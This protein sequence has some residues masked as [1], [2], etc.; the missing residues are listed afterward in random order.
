MIISNNT[1]VI[2][3]IGDP[4]HHSLSPFFQNAALRYLGLDY[5][6][7]SFRVKQKDLGNAV[8]GLRSI[9][10]H[11]FNVTMPHKVG[12]TSYIDSLDK[13]SM[14]AGSVN[15]VLNRNNRLI[16]FTTDGQ[17]AINALEEKGYNPNGNKIVLLGAGGASRSI[18]F[19]LIDK[20]RELVIINRTLDRAD[21][22]VNDLSYKLKNGAKVRSST[23]T[24]SNLERELVD[25]DIL[26][27]ATSIGMK[28]DNNF[29]PVKLDFIHSRLL[30]F[31]L[32]YYPL[33]TKLLREA[34]SQGA[35]TIDGLTMLVYQGAASLKIW[36][37]R[38]PPLDIM[39]KAARESYDKIP[40]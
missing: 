35:K 28:P 6:Y 37:G 14:N 19:S 4:I 21:K 30:V 8:K 24:P 26:I 7:L 13:S 10:V 23:L 16:G 9:G 5:V 40:L 39:M 3:L 15:T 36:T 18:S 22:L 34:R 17:G 31:D 32:V 2:G 11:G 29:S 27:N 1:K 33:E 20:I 25:A 12:I 38:K